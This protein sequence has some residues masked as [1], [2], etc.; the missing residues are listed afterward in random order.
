M[1][2]GARYAS[3]VVR[4]GSLAAA[5]VV[6]L[7]GVTAVASAKDGLRATFTK[8]IPPSKPAGEH[9]HISWKLRNSAGQ[10]VSL[11]RTF[12]KIVCPTGDSYTIT[13]AKLDA[14]G[15]YRADAI[16]PPGGIGTV[17]IG[18]KGATIRITNPF[19]G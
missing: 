15:L 10:P 12:V 9:V 8:P 17:T 16:V 13:F 18:A 11:K 7:F 5:L 14:R 19:H 6:A 4:W 2:A 3:G 1:A